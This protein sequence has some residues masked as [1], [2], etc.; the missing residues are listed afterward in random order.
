VGSVWTGR[1]TGAMDPGPG[2]M[3]EFAGFVLTWPSG[4]ACSGP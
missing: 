1:A 2:F 3:D 4:A